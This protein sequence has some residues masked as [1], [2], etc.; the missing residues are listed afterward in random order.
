MEMEIRFDSDF[1]SGAEKKANESGFDQREKNLPG[2]HMLYLN[3]ITTDTDDKGK[4]K[5]Q[6]TA[7]VSADAKEFRDIKRTWTFDPKASTDKEIQSRKVQ[8]EMFITFFYKGFGYSFK[9]GTLDKIILQTQQFKGK[10]FQAALKEVEDLKTNYDSNDPTIIVGMFIIKKMEIWYVGKADDEAFAVNEEKCKT[11]LPKDKVQIFEDF[12]AANPHLYDENGEYIKP[13]G[14]STS[15]S[16]TDAPKAD[17]NPFK[18]KAA[19]SNPFAKAN[20]AEEEKGTTATSTPAAPKKEMPEEALAK[21]DEM[22]EE[23]PVLVSPKA[24]KDEDL[25]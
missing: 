2:K 6:I 22:P 5:V 1:I 13:E 19:D 17:S 18:A 16:S 10:Q 15:S 8:Q 11:T 12:K 9:P 3:D 14:S 21:K 23:E 25:W 24:K 20:K 7:N 4:V